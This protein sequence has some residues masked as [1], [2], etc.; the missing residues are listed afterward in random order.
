MRYIHVVA[1]VVLSGCGSETGTDPTC[2]ATCGDAVVHIDGKAGIPVGV[3]PVLV[4][5]CTDQVCAEASVAVPADSVTETAGTDP[6]LSATI[7]RTS[8]PFAPDLQGVFHFDVSWSSSSKRLEEGDY[9][10]LT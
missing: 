8:D 1:I 4:K 2:D 5:V 6:K 9:A 3:D 7:E 10:V